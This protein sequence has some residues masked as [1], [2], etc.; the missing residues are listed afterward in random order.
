MMKKIVSISSNVEIIYSYIGLSVS[1]VQSW[2]LSKKR[3][4][5]RKL[6]RVNIHTASSLTNYYNSMQTLSK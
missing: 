3:E 6:F 1:V 5:E 4:S 2:S